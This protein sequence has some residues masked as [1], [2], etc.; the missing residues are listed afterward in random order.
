MKKTYLLYPIFLFVTIAMFSSCKEMD[1]TYAE[2]VVPNGLKYP[3]RADSLRVYAGFN[4]VRLKWN[5]PKDPSVTHAE[6][7]WNNYEDTLRV[8]LPQDKDTVT[9]DIAGLN[10]TTYTFYVINF[11]KEGNTSIPMETSGSPYGDHYLVGSTDR[12]VNSAL[13]DENNVG[14][15]NWG[16]KTTDLV[17]SEVRYKTTSGELETVRL[18]ADQTQLECPDI[19]PG[20]PFEYRSVFLPQKGIDSIAR[21]WQTHQTP[22]IYKYPRADWTAEARNGNHDWGDGGGGQPQLVLDGQLTTG[23]HSRVG[24]PLPQCLVVDMK[25]LLV[26]DHVMLYPPGFADWRYLNNV[27]IYLTKNPIVPDEPNPSWGTPVATATYSGA[28]SFQI[29]LDEPTEGKY[30]A[31]VF[32]DSKAA[33]NSYMSFMELEVFGY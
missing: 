19:M 26:V 29:N 33:P 13:R 5:K 31:V 32:V 18:Y 14:T 20:E 2:Y 12:A 11:D 1:S 10:E 28:D 24:T 3:Q 21:N 30:L 6:V 27:E 8:D 4:K 7:Y 25:E 9:V 17:Y 15:V 16:A 23:W 22:F